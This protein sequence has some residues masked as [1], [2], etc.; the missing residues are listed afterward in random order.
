MNQCFYLVNNKSKYVYKMNDVQLTKMA[1]IH[2]ITELKIKEVN[3]WFVTTNKDSLRS[4]Q[5]C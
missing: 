3:L 5:Y 4:V 1:K 2:K